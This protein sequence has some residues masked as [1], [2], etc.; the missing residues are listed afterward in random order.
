MKNTRWKGLKRKGRFKI[1]RTSI[2]SDVIKEQQKW[3][4]AV[5]IETR[6]ID[7]QRLQSTPNRLT[8][9]ASPFE[10]FQHS[11]IIWTALPEGFLETIALSSRPSFFPFPCLG[12]GLLL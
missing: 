1:Q 10:S 6:P 8:V 4:Y 9:L 11:D 2:K 7:Q 5:K 12:L 3:R